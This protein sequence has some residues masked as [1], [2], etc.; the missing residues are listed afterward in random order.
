MDINFL[1]VVWKMYV[2]VLRDRVVESI[3]MEIGEEQCVF[4]KCR[5][6]RDQLFVVR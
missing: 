2:N 3:E 4:R 6:Y 1:A 5:S